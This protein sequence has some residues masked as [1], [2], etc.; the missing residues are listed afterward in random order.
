MYIRSISTVEN[1]TTSIIL[2]TETKRGFQ[3][4]L[5]KIVYE[6]VLCPNDSEQNG[7]TLCKEFCERS[8]LREL[9]L[10]KKVSFSE[11]KALA[12]RYIIERGPT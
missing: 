12:R 10:I 7:I 11:H 1:P 3:T 5:M 9:N 4:L 8:Q 6:M 2:I